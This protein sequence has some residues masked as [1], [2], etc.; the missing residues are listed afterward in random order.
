M[1]LNQVRRAIERYHLL[2]QG[3]RV[4]VGVSGGIDSMVLLRLLST[5][6]LDLNLFLVVAHVNHGLRPEESEKEAA[7]VRAESERLGLP[8]EYGK[9]DVREFQ[10]TR[11]LSAQ[12]A[13]R[14]IRLHFLN[15]LL[16]KY[17]AQKI[18]L[19]HTADDQVETFLLRLIRGAGLRGL[20][21]MLPV[22]EGK[23]IHPLLDVWRRDIESFAKEN[24]IAFLL[25]S[26]NLERN[27]LRN[28]LRL[29]LIPLIEKE[30]QPGFREVV[31]RTTT[32]LREEDD[33]LEEKAGEAYLRVVHE[34]KN[35]LSFRFSEYRSLHKAIQ[36]RV[37]R[38]M[39]ERFCR[40]EKMMEDGELDLDSIY[41][42][43]TRQS[44]FA[45][46]L[47]CDVSLEKR[48][49][50]VCLKKGR[51][52][53]PPPFA[54]EIISPGRTAIA[55]IGIE[56]VIEE[57]TREDRLGDLKGAPDVA[58][59]DYHRLRFP[60]KMR[61]FRPGDRFQPLGLKGTQKVKQFF[62]D[63]KVP[64]FE[65]P[66]VPLL[67]SGET[68]AWVVGHRIDERFKVTEKTRKILRVEVLTRNGPLG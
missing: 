49:D 7:L 29:D 6:R 47:P 25:D 14:K 22:R 45:M 10:R 53:P 17:D 5:L 11:K 46:S 19:G 28:R 30:Y 1:L 42:R 64:R 56:V 20:K 52:K 44:S 58:L 68:I 51:P 24:G 65:R 16:L 35:H 12:D 3:N 9:F 60:L 23:V 59:L 50:A 57:M 21:G 39:L 33:Y 4:I 62:I 36:W 40:G 43:L 8:F 26:S 55:E 2:E 54:V 15:H 18:A 37:L 13:A 61:N 38:K 41:R 34:E 63:R 32:L 66:N 27:Y 67:I 31:A 48:Y